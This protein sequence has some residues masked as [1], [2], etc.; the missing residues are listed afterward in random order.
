MPDQLIVRARSG[1]ITRTAVLQ[2]TAAV[3]GLVVIGGLLGGFAVERLWSAPDG[4]VVRHH[5]YRGITSLDP[6]TQAQN[7]DQGVFSGLGWYAAASC[8]LGL[9]LGAAVAA[10]LARS[11][12]LTLAAVAVGG[13]AA[14]VVMR[15]VAT[16]LAPADP[17]G[18][19]RTAADGTILPDT[20]HL[21]PWWTI[22]LLPGAAL[23]G[24]AAVFLL[25][26]PRRQSIL[27]TASTSAPSP[28]PPFPSAPSNFEKSG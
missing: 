25:V 20:L 4:M 23:L 21:G 19:A 16:A 5:W 22:T 1:S 17:T 12:L 8:V 9:V 28:P 7:A 2:A 26:T 11:E 24:L 27:T 13:L 15:V 10:L 14:G 6:L 18:P 3:I